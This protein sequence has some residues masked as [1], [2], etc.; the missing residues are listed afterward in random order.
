MLTPLERGLYLLRDAPR[1][2]QREFAQLVETHP[3]PKI[4]ARLSRYATFC[5]L[6]KDHPDTGQP[7]QVISGLQAKTQDGHWKLH[8]PGCRIVN[9][10]SSHRMHEKTRDWALRS[11]LYTP[12]YHYGH[13]AVT[14]SG[15][16]I[17]VRRE[18]NLGLALRRSALWLTRQQQPG[19][20][21]LMDMAA[22]A[23]ELRAA[24]RIHYTINHRDLSELITDAQDLLGPLFTQQV[25][26]Q[27][28]GLAHRLCPETA[29]LPEAP[30]AI[31]ATLQGYDGVWWSH[32]NFGVIFSLST[33]DWQVTRHERRTKPLTSE[34][35]T[36]A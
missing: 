3:L 17:H 6:K 4:N 18:R 30:N 16:E 2:Q 32:L 13:P 9:V 22:W 11:G 34:Q 1:A 25:N 21:Q 8:R 27:A 31:W 19:S 35:R 12:A 26:P 28:S 15:T 33:A 5:A 23:D 29:Y 7:V 14:A 36:A 10:N 24:E 20:R